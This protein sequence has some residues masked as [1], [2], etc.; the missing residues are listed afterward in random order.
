MA[1]VDTLGTVAGSFGS[2][3]GAVFQSV[4]P[5]GLAQPA[6][7]GNSRRADLQ[8]AQAGARDAGK[9]PVQGHYADSCDRIAGGCI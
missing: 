6:G 7:R 8:C 4:C 1:E 2:D 5:S 9:F 3:L